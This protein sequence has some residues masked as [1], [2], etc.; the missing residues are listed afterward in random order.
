LLVQKK[1]P[2]K[3][4]NTSLFGEG[5]LAAG[6]QTWGLDSASSHWRSGDVFGLFFRGSMFG[7]RR[8]VVFVI[9]AFAGMTAPEGNE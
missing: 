1:S 9:P 2:R 5:W 7:Q 4:L 3:H 8:A 6:A